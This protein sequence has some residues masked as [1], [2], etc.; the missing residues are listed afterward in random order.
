MKQGFNRIKRGIALILSFAL[1]ISTPV[2]NMSRVQAIEAPGTVTRESIHDGAILHAFCWSFD[3]IKEN[4]ADIAAA[5]YT[6]IQT[7]PINACLDTNPAMTL[8]GTGAWYYHYQPTDWT[9]GNYQLGTRAEFAEMCAV[10]ESYGIGIIVDIVPN[11]TTPSLSQVSNDL[12]TAAGGSE[13]LYHTTSDNI[14]SYSDRFECT[15]YQSGGLPDVDTENTGFQAYFYDYLTDAIACGAD[16]FRIDT[17]KHIGL[18][19]DDRPDGVENTFYPNMKT[20]LSNDGDDKDYDDLFV[21]GEVLQGANERLAAYQDMLGGTT[22]SKYGENIRTALTT[23]DYSVSKISGYAISDDTYTATTYTADADK[24]VTW[25]ESHDTYFNDGESWLALDDEKVVKGWAIITARAA[26]TPLFFSRPAGSSSTSREGN[27]VLG[28][29]GND[30][31][32]DAR[33]SAVNH[34]RLAMQGKAENLRNPSGNVNVI[35]IERGDAGLVMVN[36]ASSAY[37]L[38]SETNL[39]DGTYIDKVDGTSVYT[40]KNGV[41][42]GV[43]PA[44]GV[45]VLYEAEASNATS[46]MFYNSEDWSSV[47]ATVDG[48][49]GAATLYTNGDGW[50]LATVNATSFEISFTDG[51]N[52]SDAFAITTLTDRYL[53]GASSTLYASKSAA[54]TG[55]GIRNVSVYF[56]N[57]PLWDDVYAYIWG[58]G[59]LLGGWPGK[60]TSY[61]GDYWYRANIKVPAGATDFNIIFNNNAGSQTDSINISDDVNI[62][63]TVENIAYDDREDAEDSVGFSS[64]FTDVYYYNDSAWDE[65]AAYTWG[66]ANNFGDWPGSASA[67]IDDGDGWFKV[68]LQDGA[69]SALYLIFNNNNNG[70]Q[71]PNINIADAKNVYIAGHNGAKYASKT[72][73]EEAL[74]ISG[75]EMKV[76]FYDKNHWDNLYAYAY[77]DG[78]SESPLGAWPGAAMTTDTNGWKYITIPTAASDNLKVIFNNN[79]GAQTDA[80]TVND[81]TMHYYTSESTT[82]YANKIAAE[83][84]ID[85]PR[86]TTVCHF[87]NSQDWASVSAY[88]YGNLGEAFGGWPGAAATDDGNGWFSVEVPGLVSDGFTIIFNNSNNGKQ[89]ADLTPSSQTNVWTYA[90]TG[91]TLL[92]SQAAVESIVNAINSNTT[93]YYYNDSWANTY[94]YAYID[95]GTDSPLGTWPGTLMTDDGNNWKTV[96]IPTAAS[97]NLKVIFNDGNGNQISD[98]TVNSRDNNCFTSV[99]GNDVYATKHAAEADHSLPFS[100]TTV[101]FYDSDN[102]GNVNAYT[103]GDLGELLGGWPGAAATDDG[104]GWWHITVPAAYTD[105]FNLIFNN[106]SVQS[107]TFAVKN[108]REGFTINARGTVFENKADVDSIINPPVTPTPTPTPAPTQTPAASTNTSSSEA[109]PATIALPKAVTGTEVKNYESTLSRNE[110]RAV[111]QKVS[112]DVKKI[113]DD[114]ESATEA[115]NKITKDI[116]VDSLAVAMQNDSN[117]LKQIKNLEADYNAENNITVKSNVDSSLSN[118]VDPSSVSVVGAGLNAKSGETVTLSLSAPTTDENVDERVYKNAIALD[119]KLQGGSVGSKLDVPVSITMKVPGNLN[120]SKLVILHYSSDGSYEVIRPVRNADGSITF[121]VTHFSTFVFAESAV[122]PK[123]GENS[124]LYIVLFSVMGM[125]AIASSAIVYKKRFFLS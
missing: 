119:I 103:Y 34:F 88:V 73:A 62:Y 82:V 107:A 22:A 59:E 91:A 23:G 18:P 117:V 84:A 71:T 30:F 69:S 90:G 118:V 85:V 110:R 63:T 68:R 109:A 80:Y 53:T 95:G 60:A 92:D 76:Y 1:L 101:H 11:H 83:T 52:T 86:S 36:S 104:D 13:L 3:T 44:N 56:L 20:T 77:I 94:A 12:I 6:A 8:L 43:V 15:R 98:V 40:V 7:S 124:L 74:G 67:V 29:A 105:G 48:S 51:E 65:I 25:V 81:R 58:P 99:S 35:M 102:W 14:S 93:I 61:V 100:T 31:Y 120:I 112:N 115:L 116:S 72:A 46:V 79:A 49:A 10:A 45:V 57:S 21:Y 19:D 125:A 38:D 28:A 37:V 111:S 113:V 96:S 97:D 70:S 55:L 47:S 17:A 4:M 66:G 64:R 24:L 2:G 54:E 75:Q 33:V 89:T 41:I 5:G 114:N 9:I 32:K 27:N 42:N 16:G 87:Y 39:A 106:N 78:G 121:T 26:G 123:T 50:Y 108:I 122:S